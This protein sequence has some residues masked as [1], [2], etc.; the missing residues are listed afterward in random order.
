MITL[1]QGRLIEKH[2]TH[3]V[4]DCQGVGYEVHISLNTYSQLGSEENI[5]LYTHL[6][7]REDAHTLY[8]FYQPVERSIFRFVDLHFGHRGEHCANHAFFHDSGRNSTG[9]C[10]RK[11]SGDKSGKRDWFKDRTAGVDRAKRQNS[12]S[13]RNGRNSCL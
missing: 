12:N 1:L 13:C 2:P 10:P 5:R 7:I 11:F 9:H 4:I 6:Q 8:G 3:V